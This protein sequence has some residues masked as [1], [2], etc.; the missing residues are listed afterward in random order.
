MLAYSLTLISDPLAVA[1]CPHEDAWKV[2]IDRGVMD[3]TPT[4]DG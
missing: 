4:P 1:E 3:H 2:M